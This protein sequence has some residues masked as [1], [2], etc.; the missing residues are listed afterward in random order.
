MQFAKNYAQH[1][2]IF[3]MVQTNPLKIARK[4]LQVG[5]TICTIFC[6]TVQMVRGAFRA[7]CTTTPTPLRSR[8][9]LWCNGAVPWCGEPKALAW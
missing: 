9:W 6:T 4:S 3:H 2:T 7:A 5:C 1:C 8:G